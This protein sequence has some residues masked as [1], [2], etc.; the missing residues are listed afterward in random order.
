MHENLIIKHNNSY[1]GTENAD[2]EKEYA[3]NVSKIGNNLN[4]FASLSF[5]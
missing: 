5:L 3:E 1:F 2:F 4:I